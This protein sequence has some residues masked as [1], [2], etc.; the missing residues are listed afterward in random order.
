MY[1]RQQPV[2]GSRHSFA[3]AP[4]YITSPMRRPVRVETYKLTGTSCATKLSSR[5]QYCGSSLVSASATATA[6]LAMLAG[7]MAGCKERQQAITQ[8]SGSHTCVLAHVSR[9]AIAVWGT[10]V[11][12]EGLK[13]Q[14]QAGGGV[15]K[16]VTDSF[17]HSPSTKS[18]NVR[19]TNHRVWNSVAYMLY[20]KLN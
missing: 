9:A 20:N 1:G 2:D 7:A 8:A 19:L 12:Q 14:Q 10:Q 11:Q 15:A 18:H 17:E 6:E 3:V 13:E 16:G 4:V 5:R